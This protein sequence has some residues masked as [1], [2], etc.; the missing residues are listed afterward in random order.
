VVDGY[1]R[2]AALE[3]FVQD[4]APIGQD[5][6]NSLSLAFTVGRKLLDVRECAP[7]F[8]TLSAT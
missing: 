1:T 8:L 4:S 7:S 6:H 3:E 2:I 5:R